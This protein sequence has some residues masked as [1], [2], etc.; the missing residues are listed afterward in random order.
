MFL[1]QFVMTNRML[2]VE[3]RS[4]K[5][6]GCA[7]VVEDEVVDAVRDDEVDGDEPK[8]HT[9]VHHIVTTQHL[10]VLLYHHMGFHHK[11]TVA[12]TQHTH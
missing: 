7:H 8:E 9:I 11:C 6:V 3:G 1:N 10:H 5:T 2:R 4:G 12:R